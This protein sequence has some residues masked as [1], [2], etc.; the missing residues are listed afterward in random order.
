MCEFFVKADPILY[1]T[2]SRTV[3]IHGVLTSIRLE[4]LVW[5]LLAQMAADE[6]CTTNSLIATF[7]DEIME[8]QRRAFYGLRQRVLEGR[9]VKGLIFDYIDQATRTACDD[10][11]D[12]GY[13]AQCAAE[14]ARQVIDIPIEPDRLKGMDQIEMEKQIRS[15]AKEEARQQISVTMG[16]YMPSEGS[17]FAMDFDAEGLAQWAKGHFGVE[18]DPAELR[19]NGAS[20]RREAPPW[21]QPDAVAH[22]RALT[23]A[24]E[25]TP[26]RDYRQSGAQC[27]ERGVAT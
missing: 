20:I 5:D 15:D 24:H 4:N 3:R 14:Y 7:H 8:H 17:E 26:G 1:E 27:V 12:K 11:L 10:F 18:L 9:D 22:R 21:A 19:R 23:S 2:R 13:A 6:G 25:L 16:E